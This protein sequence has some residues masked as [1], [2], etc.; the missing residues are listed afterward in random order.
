M[1][2]DAPGAGRYDVAAHFT[3]APDYGILQITPNGKPIG[4]PFDG[5]GQGVTLGDRVTLG[6][7][8][9]KAGANAL[10]MEVTGKHRLSSG[11]FVGLDRILLTPVTAQVPKETQMASAAGLRLMR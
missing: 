2:L 7:A 9:L 10:V 4:A 1:T 3:R 5:Y 8:D 6:A 11:Y